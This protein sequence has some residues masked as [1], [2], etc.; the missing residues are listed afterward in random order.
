MRGAESWCS[1]SSATR[2]P[3]GGGGMQ[4]LRENVEE[5]VGDAK[6]NAEPRAKFH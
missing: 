6:F 5:A 1:L 4:Y 3:A 2:R